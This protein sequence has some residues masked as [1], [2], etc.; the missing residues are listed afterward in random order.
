MKNFKKLMTGV[1]MVAALATT[2]LSSQ[3]KCTDWNQNSTSWYCFSSEGS[4]ISNQWI[5][6]CFLQPSSE[7]SI[8]QWIGSCYAGATSP[9]STCSIFSVK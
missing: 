7:V 2:T 6:N 9:N 4:K 8:N 3:A 1:V 5:G